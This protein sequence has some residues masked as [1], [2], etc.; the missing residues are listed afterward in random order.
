LTFTNHGEIGLIC[1][2][3]NSYCLVGSGGSENFYSSIEAELEDVIPI[4]KTSIGD[5]SVGRYCIGF[6][7]LLADPRIIGVPLPCK[8]G[9]LTQKIGGVWHPCAE[10]YTWS[11]WDRCVPRWVA[12][13][14]NGL[15]LPH[16]TTLEVP[17]PQETNPIV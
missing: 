13:N 2:L 7:Y 10:N 16:T 4:I 17:L 12:G 3:T 8:P 11:W 14:K 1:N 5:S 6:T 15:L 9:G